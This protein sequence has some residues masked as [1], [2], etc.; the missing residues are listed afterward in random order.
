MI[1][2]KFT[3][4]YKLINEYFGNLLQYTAELSGRKLA[5][6][7]GTKSINID[8]AKKLLSVSKEYKIKNCFKILCW[9]GYYIEDEE[10]LNSISKMKVN[11]MRGRLDEI[12]LVNYVK[13][14]EN[15]K[16]AT[17]AKF[18][19]DGK[20][21]L[22][23]RQDSL[24]LEK[25]NDAIK[26]Y[27]IEQM[28]IYSD[29]YSEENLKSYTPG[30]GKNPTFLEDYRKD[31]IKAI[32]KFLSDQYPSYKKSDLYLVTAKLIYIF[33][34]PLKTKE[35]GETKEVFKDYFFDIQEII[36]QTKNIILRP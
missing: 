16:I 30:K 36:D 24:L 13:D 3:P 26:L 22:I 7:Q 32:F 6:F 21:S 23:A 18:Y 33:G 10:V 4:N 11:N 17:G 25:L 28:D 15:G 35:G 27:L 9:L 19:L 14:I 31:K 5:Y 8:L 1:E 34:L 29:H 2:F 12:K 20:I